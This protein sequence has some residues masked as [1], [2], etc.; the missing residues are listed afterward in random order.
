MD[1]FGWLAGG[2]NQ[3]NTPD[4][5]LTSSYD[6]PEFLKIH[7]TK[8][9]TPHRES[10]E[11]DTYPLTPLES[12]LK[13]I[14]LSVYSDKKSS[15]RGDT[16]EEK[17]NFLQSRNDLAT[18][19][20]SNFSPGQNTQQLEKKSK[21]SGERLYRTRKPSATIRLN[22]DSSDYQLKLTKSQSPVHFLTKS[23]EGAGCYSEGQNN[24][25]ADRSLLQSVDDF[26]QTGL[27]VHHPLDRSM[28]DTHSNAGEISTSAPFFSA[29]DQDIELVD[30]DF[31]PPRELGGLPYSTIPSRDF[32]EKSNDFFISEPKSY[33]P[34]LEIANSSPGLLYSFS[35]S[36]NSNQHTSPRATSKRET[37]M[38]IIDSFDVSPQLYQSTI[39]KPR[40]IPSVV[41]TARNTKHKNVSQSKVPSSDDEAVDGSPRSD[42][43]STGDGDRERRDKTPTP[44]SHHSGHEAVT[45]Q[46]T[47]PEGS[48]GTP[49]PLSH[50]SGREAGSGSSHRSGHEADVTSQVT[51]PEGSD[52]TPIPLLH[53]SG[54]EAGSGSSPVSKP[55]GSDNGE[56]RDKTPTPSSHHSRHETVASQV[57]EPEGSDETPILLS[58]HSGREAGSGSSPV[59]KPE[60][61][62]NGECKDETPIPHS[63]HEAVTSQVTKPEG[64]GETPIPSSLHHGHEAITSPEG[65]DKTPIRLSLHHGH[66]A[67][68][69]PVTKP[70]SPGNCSIQEL[71]ADGDSTGMHLALGTPPDPVGSNLDQLPV[72]LPYLTRLDSDSISVVSVQHLTEVYLNDPMESLNDS[73]T[74]A[75]E[76]GKI[77][78]IFPNFKSPATSSLPNELSQSQQVPKD[79]LHVPP[80][81]DVVSKQTRISSPNK[82]P[83]HIHPFPMPASQPK[84]T[85]LVSS[86]ISEVSQIQVLPSGPIKTPEEDGQVSHTAP[87]STLHP[88]PL[89]IKALHLERPFINSSK[90]ATSV[91][92]VKPLVP[93]AFEVAAATSAEDKLKMLE[94]KL[95][96]EQKAQ[97]Y[98]EGQLEAV[99]EECETA[100]KERPDLLTRL[101]RAEA[102]L[103]EMA[104]AL[105]R[106]KLRSQS[107]PS[108]SSEGIRFHS[109][110]VEKD[111]E[112]TKE[113]LSK[114]KDITADLRN[115]LAR[116]EQRANRLERDLEDARRNMQDQ[117]S[118]LS[119][120][121]DKLKN[122]QGEMEKMAEESEERACKLSSL[123]ASYDALE[124]NKTWLHDQLQDALKSKLS[125][126]EELRESKA[127][128][129]AHDIKYNQ[130]QKENSVLQNQ[131]TDLQKGIL[132]DK[133]KMVSQLEAIEADVL[134][135]EGSQA[136]LVSEKNQL[137]D[138]ARR[139]DE[140]LSHLGSDLARAQVE[141][142]ELQQKL[143]Q[144]G[145][146]NNKLVE[147]LGREHKNVSNKL[148]ASMRDLEDKESDLREMVKVK[149]SLQ[150]KLR[151]TDAELISKDGAIQGLLEAKDLLQHE[152]DLTKEAKV[153]L[154]KES[155]DMKQEVAELEADL[156][157]A[158]EKSREKDLKLK[159]ISESQHTVDDQKQALQAAL[160]EK[161]E[162]IERKEESIQALETQIHELLGEF[163]TLRDN[164]KSIASKS[165][166]VTDSI[167][168][169]DRV[170]SHLSL[171]KD[172]T[173]KELRSLEEKNK[174]L[175]NELDHLQHE[176][177]HLQGQVEGSVNQDDYRKSL[178][179]RGEM[180]AELNALKLSQQRDQIKAQ[181]KMNRLESNVKDA[182]KAASKAQRDLLRVQD[183]KKEEIEKLNE[184][185]NRTEAHSREIEEKLQRALKDKERAEKILANLKPSEGQVELLRNKCEQLLS[186][187]HDLTEKLHEE[188]QQR[189]EVERASG[190]VASKL[191]QN[192]EKEKKD[193]LQKYQD[194]SLEVERLRG[195]LAGM[196][197][198]QA[199]MRDHATNLEVTLAKKESSIVKLSAEAQKVLEEKELE[200]HAFGAKI[201]TLEKQLDDL[202]ADVAAHREK[203]QSEIIRA[204]ELER[205]LMKRES[206]LA[207]MQVELSRRESPVTNKQ[208]TKL[209][210][211]KEALQ[212]DISYLRSQLLVA[213]TAAESAKREVVDKTSQV[214]ILGREL[215]LVEARCQQA[216]DEVKQLKEHLKLV[217]ARHREEIEELRRAVREAETSWES[218]LLEGQGRGTGGLLDATLS[219][220]SGNDEVDQPNL[221]A[222]SGKLVSLTGQKWPL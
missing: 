81:P 122:S 137:E 134:S 157:S 98:L 16:S 3:L 60:D 57:T 121:Q 158:L 30:P 94:E 155:V 74:P 93:N 44:L 147:D 9:P 113:A 97:M 65:S 95:A 40:S 216:D 43:V 167:A 104:S 197:T 79:Q 48:D 119:V 83:A 135:T 106:E 140:A 35:D 6:P 19:D 125:L 138:L 70:E 196:H 31:T 151:Q 4:R 11:C 118:A 211:E 10:P 172:K 17:A 221:A 51:K 18:H 123:E 198:T 190:L 68:T 45:S 77:P 115:H 66:E 76:A 75:S 186:Q 24:K 49:I 80:S 105:E 120:L 38:G 33:P 188:S 210:S 63:G 8:P 185:K 203:A 213:K 108:S 182:Q 168:E 175:R 54:R 133:A 179:D 173:E 218:T 58:H 145:R 180:Q 47:K 101:S 27:G 176:R 206:E 144:V 207:S 42:L 163:N 194:L 205:K 204:Q 217:D 214:E 150:E 161:E 28:S 201:S 64:S 78:F 85:D 102:K 222:V 67:I 177:A 36:S 215:K 114:E 127:S 191:K 12:R 112:K 160:A 25:T 178:Q 90:A 82:I 59:S 53:R 116:E 55:E 39:A 141:L 170:I 50:H 14:I 139:K 23:E 169:K 73:M 15:K 99:K 189:I 132:Q 208:L 148:T 192:A 22:P 88:E 199:T 87:G 174:E 195:R 187:N 164:F 126:Q 171:E 212:S 146:D 152:L 153:I 20:Q 32:L 21:L 107:K 103:I 143:K 209:S 13:D 61:S 183:E 62:D 7:K 219:T 34:S 149:N 71:K 154:E 69:S 136:E 1:L 110:Q 26:S 2:S 159:D 29:N 52:E 166:T 84:S 96:D 41:G 165:D 220:I 181:A 184:M 100:L 72:E 156:K 92:N 109:E 131:I 86:E 111:L 193:L 37:H 162:E 124:K 130:L 142:E 46:V 117:E 200:D 5:P 128:G 56:R 202:N 129:I 89:D 91:S